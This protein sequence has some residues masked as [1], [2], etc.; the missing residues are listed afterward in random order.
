MSRQVIHQLAIAT[1]RGKMTFPQ[2]VK[3]LIEVGVES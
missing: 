1:Q 2:V 3:G